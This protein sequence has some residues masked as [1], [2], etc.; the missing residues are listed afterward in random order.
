M[1]DIDILFIHNQITNHIKNEYTNIDNLKNKIK[2]LDVFLLNKK[3]SHG[4]E[5]KIEKEKKEIYKTINNIQNNNSYNFYLMEVMDI[6]EEY[7]EKLSNPI[8]INFMGKQKTN[9][10]DNNK[11]IQAYLQIAKPYIN[12][13]NININEYDKPKTKKRKNK[14]NKIKIICNNCNS[15]ELDQIDDNYVCLKCGN[16]IEIYH[17]HSSYKDIERVNM[18]PKYTYDRKTHFRDCINQYQGKQNV[19]ISQDIYN[20]LIKQFELHSLLYGNEYTSKEDRFK[21]ITKDHIYIFLKE[22]HYSKYYE[23][24]TLIHYNITGKKPE[25][26][27]HL[28]TLLLDDFDTLTQLYDKIYKKDKKIERKNF[29]NTQYVLFQL[30]RRHKNQCKR[31]EFNIL[32][33]IDRKSFHDDVCKDLFN[34]LGWNFT[35]I[36]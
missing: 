10:K 31:E 32:K 23:D 36:F 15:E 35:S 2:N 30:L 24:I 33:T 25:D 17:K 11:I 6:I 28:E 18:V 20:Y 9:K 13:F 4:T 12:K 29:I 7:K 5:K 21:N 3:I 8:E 16:V 14:I 22:G 19:T 27:S 34:R 1:P 26:I